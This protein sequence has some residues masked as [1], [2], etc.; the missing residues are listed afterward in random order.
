[1]TCDL[2]ILYHFLIDCRH[3]SL[4][5]CYPGILVTLTLYDHSMLTVFLCDLLCYFFRVTELLTDCIIYSSTQSPYLELDQQY[6]TMVI[7]I[8]NNSSINHMK[9]PILSMQELLTTT[10]LTNLSTECTIPM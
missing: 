7:S 2:C 8:D 3:Q 9:P 6:A 5:H 1:M 4:R 10:S